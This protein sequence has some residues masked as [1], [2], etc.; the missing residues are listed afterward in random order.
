MMASAA[1]FPFLLLV[2]LVILPSAYLYDYYGYND[3]YYY[4]NDNYNN[5]Y[6]YNDNYKYV[7]RSSF[8]SCKF[9]HWQA[10]RCR[11]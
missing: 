6:N 2:C 7:L 11:K 1:P 3:N 5:Y 10:Q 9:T 4:Y 8:F